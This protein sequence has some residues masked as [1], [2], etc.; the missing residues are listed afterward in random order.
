MGSADL[1]QKGAS[2]GRQEGMVHRSGSV[3]V[4]L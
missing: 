3:N 2:R 4:P 1:A